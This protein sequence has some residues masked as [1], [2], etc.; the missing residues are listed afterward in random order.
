MF[1]HTHTH[2]VVN[3]ILNA[4][5]EMYIHVIVNL[6]VMFARIMLTVHLFEEE[7]SEATQHLHVL[8]VPWLLCVGLWSVAQ[9]TLLWQ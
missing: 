8:H 6:F 3:I 4:H 7:L 9:L 2:T 5:R 1:T